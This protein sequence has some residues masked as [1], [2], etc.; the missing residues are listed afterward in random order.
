MKGFLRYFRSVVL[1]G[2]FRKPIG[3]H[4]FQSCQF[5]SVVRTRRIVRIIRGSFLYIILVALCSGNNYLNNFILLKIHYLQHDTLKIQFRSRSMYEFREDFLFYDSRVISKKNEKR[6]ST[7][8]FCVRVK[9]KCN[10]KSIFVNICEFSLIFPAVS[11]LF[12]FIHCFYRHSSDSYQTISIK[13][14]NYK[15]NYKRLY[16]CSNN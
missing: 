1:I 8:F 15:R 14:T 12:F 10:R 9:C 5:L 16:L 7:Y 6:F 11:N 4:I 13:R 3:L 2:R